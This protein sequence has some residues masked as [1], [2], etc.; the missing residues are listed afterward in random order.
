MT[1]KEAIIDEQRR[2]VG[3]YKSAFEAFEKGATNLK[4]ALKLVKDEL[5]E[6]EIKVVEGIQLAEEEQRAYER[7]RNELGKLTDI[8]GNI[9]AQAKILSDDYRQMNAALEVVAVGASAFGVAQGAMALFGSESEKVAR[10]LQ[11]L[12]AVQTMLASIQKLQNSLNKDGRIM[13]ELQMLAQ[14]KNTAVKKA[15]IAVTRV[16]N[17]ALTSTNLLIGGGIALLGLAVVGISKYIKKGK[18]TVDV[19]KQE[20]KQLEELEK[21][22]QKEAKA[23]EKAKKK[24][25][26][27]RDSILET[28]KARQYSLSMVSDS[29]ILDKANKI[30]KSAIEYY[31]LL[32]EEA[33]LSAEYGL[34]EGEEPDWLYRDFEE[35]FS[36]QIK[37][38]TQDIIGLTNELDNQ[39]KVIGSFDKD[40]ATGVNALMDNFLKTYDNFIKKTT[41]SNENVKPEIIDPLKK[42][43]EEQSIEISKINLQFIETQNELY[44]EFEAGLINYETYLDKVEKLE[45][46]YFEGGIKVQIEHLEEQKS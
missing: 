8:Q 10:S 25:E 13:I 44:N 9:S 27:Y 4:G 30:Y 20:A 28:I 38:Y 45:K 26:E 14:S 42:L 16:L 6:L 22:R 15:A 3:N 43:I 17:T 37:K 5:A 2:N 41:K 29:E 12:V 32:S 33:L 24:Q 21:R 19:Q 46:R 11:K 23:L 35:E 1:P 7:L 36:S 39:R 34:A 40:A 18:E 31:R